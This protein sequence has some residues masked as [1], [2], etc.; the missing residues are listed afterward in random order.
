MNSIN[1][2]V[3]CI[4]T[5]YRRKKEI[6]GRAIDSILAQTYSPI[7]IYIIDDNRGEGAEIFSGG[8][9][10]LSSER[11]NVPIIMTEG[12][13]GGQYARNTGIRYSKGEYVAFLDDD[14][15]WLPEKIEKQVRLMNEHPECGMC[16]TDGYRVYD[17]RKGSGRELI[18]ANYF[19]DRLSFRDLLHED[20]IGSTSQALIR[21]SVFDEVGGFDTD[22]P[23]RQDYEMWLRISRKFPIR[24]INEGLYLYHRNSD[25][26]KIT[27]DWRKNV[28]AHRLIGEK[29][30]DD[31][32]GDRDAGFNV[33][34]HTAHYYKEGFGLEKHFNTKVSC[35]L[36][37]VYYYL[38]AL[39]ISP[40][41][42]FR[43]A[44][45]TIDSIRRKRSL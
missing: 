40:G 2:L 1:P 14:D 42:F 23:A 3:S 31:I 44:G 43:Q 30:R 13:H 37:A 7:E 22:M 36:H 45:Y 24:G 16:Y 20:R 33:I 17:D 32:M 4:I 19:R 34:F 15:E 28:K 10:E 9:K 8:L 18:H 26:G 12:G 25:E 6:V 39:L 21:R 11:E 27:R 5:S 41:F 35:L 29:Y 38:R